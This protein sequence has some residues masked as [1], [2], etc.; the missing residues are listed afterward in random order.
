MD[1]AKKWTQLSWGHLFQLSKMAASMASR[2][3]LIRLMT[4]SHSMIF[5]EWDRS[6]WILINTDY[7]GCLNDSRRIF[8][9]GSDIYVGSNIWNRFLNHHPGEY[10][11]PVPIYMYV[12]IFGTD[13]IIIIK[14][15]MNILETSYIDKLSWNKQLS[16][17]D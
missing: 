15:I 6:C 3:F 12:V 5:S 16:A 4:N 14:S 10:L 1:T 13:F 8:G 11:E 7:G 2:S 9:T 17:G